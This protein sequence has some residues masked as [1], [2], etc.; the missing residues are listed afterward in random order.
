[1]KNNIIFGTMINIA[2][3]II[4]YIIPAYLLWKYL[5]PK[6]WTLIIFLACYLIAVRTLKYLTTIIYK[7]LTNKSEFD[8]LIDSFYD[9][10]DR[11]KWGGKY[12]NLDNNLI[13]TGGSIFEGLFCLK[14]LL[15][16]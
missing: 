14:K 15:K 8:Q 6:S 4:I 3:L 2:F 9:V 12:S 11:D 13:I 7:I 1:M 10:Y 5:H 16:D